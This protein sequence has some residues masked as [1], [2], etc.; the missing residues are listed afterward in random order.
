[1]QQGAAAGGMVQSQRDVKGAE[2]IFNMF[3]GGGG[4]QGRGGFQ[5]QPYEDPVA[6]GTVGPDLVTRLRY[7]E[8]LVALALTRARGAHCL[9]I[10]CIPCT[11]LR[12]Y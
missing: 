5:W 7:T 1:M 4:N 11:Q 9:C 6:E 10:L 3:F 12:R 2:E 8:M